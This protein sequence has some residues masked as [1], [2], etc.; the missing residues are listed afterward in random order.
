MSKKQLKQYLKE[1]AAT[2]RTTK[3]CVKNHQRKHNGSH[4]WQ[5]EC[6]ESIRKLQYEYRHHLIAYSILRGRTYEQVENKCAEDNS[7]N[8]D[9]VQR[10]MTEHAENVC[11]G[12]EESK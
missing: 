9:Y 10:I 5:G 4:P 11:V 6:G 7:P 12:A 1:T 2:I 3:H 8:M